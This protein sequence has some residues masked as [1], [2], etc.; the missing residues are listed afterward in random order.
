MRRVYWISILLIFAFINL[1]SA[2]EYTEG[3]YAPRSNYGFF[4]GYGFNQHTGDFSRIQGTESCC[5]QYKDGTGSG[6][7]GGL[8]YN[9]PIDDAMEIQFRLAYTDLSGQLLR[10]G[11]TIFSTPQGDKTGG[12]FEY[13]VDGTFTSIGLTPMLNYK[14]TD[15]FHLHG[16]FRVGLLQTAEYE[17]VEKLTDPAY[18]VFPDTRKR[19]RNEFSGELPGKASIESAIVLG[20]SF[21]MPMNESN[22]LFFVPEFYY[23][24]GLTSFGDDLGW[25]AQQIAGG[26][27]IKFAPRALVPE[28]PPPPPPPIPPMPIPMPPP[29]VPVLNASISAVSVDED[30]VESDMT[31]ITV[32]EFLQRKILPLLNFVFFD[33]NQSELPE[34][35][36]SL[37]QADAAKFNDKELYN[38]RTLEVYRTILNIVGERM[39]EFRQAKLNLVGCNADLG[40]EKGNTTLSNNRAQAVKDYL[41]NTWNIA[42]D[43][44]TIEAR[45]LPDKPSNENE[46]DGQQENR[47]VEMTSNF[48][49]IFEPL[50]IRDTLTITNPPVL[51]FKPEVFAEIGIQSWIL[52]T[53]QSN[54]E[55]KVFKGTGQPPT[56]IDWDLE[57]ERE[58]I[59]RL[60]ED[61]LY[62]LEVVDNDNKIWESPMQKLPVKSL[63]VQNKFMAMLDGEVLNDV[64]FDMYSLIS[65]AYNSAELTPFHIPII[66]QAKRRMADADEFT[67]EIQG[68]TDRTGTAELNLDLSQRRADAAAV[69]LKVDKKFAK[70]FGKDKPLYNNDLPEGRFYNRT[71]YIVLETSTT[72]DLD[73]ME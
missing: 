50:I 30:G 15:Q 25:K 58:F 6:L 73:D 20:A 53:A 66:D 5:D 24:I 48:P 62:K 52:T 1:T 47:R 68:Y 13:T 10:T 46:A 41:V 26:I 2:Q 33:E 31:N 65:F 60:D 45:N 29:E 9:L 64:Q 21:D 63:T 17:Q 7:S 44:I 57:S 39:D 19:T 14:V 35:Y 72:L 18:G 8:Y 56:A 38:Q 55:L 59:P 23:S 22:T 61:F 69:G 70:G 51:R 34:R 36:I 4:L 54:G 71:V 67:I 37:S 28:L 42:E 27:G 49:Q 40:P 16:G 32:E 3:P 11:S 43:R 12:T